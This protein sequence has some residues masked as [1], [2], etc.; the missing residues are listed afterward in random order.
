MQARTKLPKLRHTLSWSL[1]GNA[2]YVAAQWAMLVVLAK[3]G[4]PQMVG[5]FALGLAISAPLIMFSN[6]ELRA[7]QATDAIRRYR[8]GDYLVLRISATTLAL[9]ALVVIVLVVGYRGQ[10]ALT[11]LVVGVA[12]AFESVSDL[13]YG[14]FLQYEHVDRMA[15]SLLIKSPLSLGG[16][17]LGVY[18]TNSVVGG[19]CGLVIVWA[20]LLFGYDV[21]NG[22]RI[23]KTAH[24]ESSGPMLGHADPNT[25]PGPRGMIGRL[26]DLA[27]LALPLGIVGLL[28]NLYPNIPRYFVQEYS[29]ASALGIFATMAYTVV[30]GIKIVDS[31][32]QS[33]GPRLAGH[34]AVGNEA[35]FRTV[36]FKAVGIG[37]SFGAAGVLLVLV[38]GPEILTLFYGKEYAGY[39]GVFL[40]LAIAGAIECVATFQY[41]TITAA[42]RFAI[43][44]PLYGLV[45]CTSI[46]ACVWLVPST[47]LRGAA[48]ACVLAAAV[49][50]CG[51]LGIIAYVLHTLHGRANRQEGTQ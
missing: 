34:H 6:L 16:L 37:L 27:W 19:A 29:G 28:V 44:I 51:G 36:M 23:L 18:L 50:L 11:I 10:T 40:L 35:R 15:K 24:R 17:G 9:S 48:V 47:G 2:T 45:A 22:R 43:Q 5:Q 30:A 7:V 38:A 1:A 31:L 13:F 33:V 39:P 32:A 42:R 25:E 12:K 20:I 8:F 26:R 41:W 46:V 49:R 21:R 3:I 4:T 14:L